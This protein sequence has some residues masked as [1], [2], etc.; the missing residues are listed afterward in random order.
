VSASGAWAADLA[1]RHERIAFD[2]N[3]L[4]YLLEG[5]GPR[6]EAVAALID[7]MAA[8]GST[9]V[10]APIGIS[11]ILVGPARSGDGVGFEMLASALRSLRFVNPA[12]DADAA[13]DAAWISGRGGLALPDALHIA[14]ALAAGATAFVTN[15][16][17]IRSRPKL[18]VVYLDD[19]LA[20]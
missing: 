2:S 16:R 8:V 12:V 20:I 4:I 15:D 10:L 17:R 19:A 13:E 6:S 11:E 14:G 5:R 7:E 1:R 3:A 9:G 18:E